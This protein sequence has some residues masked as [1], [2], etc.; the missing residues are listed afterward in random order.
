MAPTRVLSPQQKVVRS[1]F[2]RYA[3]TIP[4]IYGLARHAVPGHPGVPSENVDHAGSDIYTTLL[5]ELVDIEGHDVSVDIL[6]DGQLNGTFSGTLSP[7]PFS[8]HT[9]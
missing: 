8:K 9:L 7:F 4:N 5:Q 3:C 2:K 6:P 1:F